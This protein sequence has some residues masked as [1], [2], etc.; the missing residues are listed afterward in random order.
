MDLRNPFGLKDGQIVMIEDIPQ[1][2]NGQR[3]GRVL[4][5]GRWFQ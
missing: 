4:K 2:M 3:F 1:S 5:F